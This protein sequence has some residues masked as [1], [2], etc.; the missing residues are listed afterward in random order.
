MAKKKTKKEKNKNKFEYNNEIIGVIIILLGIIGL[1]G[2]GIVGNIVKSF[3]IFL[4]GTIYVAL[5]I[6]LLVIG[7]FLILKKD[8]PNLL[9]SRLIG[10]YI[11]IISFLVILH[12]KYIEVNGT[13]S[14]KIITETF[15]NLLLSFSNN[16]ALSN[17]GGGIIGAIFSYLFVTAFGDGAQIVIYTMF[18]LGV[19]LTLNVSI[20]DVYNKIKPHISNLF[21]RDK[22]DEEEAEE[23]PN[24]KV[25]IDDN[26]NNSLEPA[27]VVEP[28]K[29]EKI[30]EDVPIV[31]PQPKIVSNESEEIPDEVIINSSAN[32]QLPSINLLNTVKNVSNKENEVKAKENIVELEKVLK[33]FDISGKVVQVNI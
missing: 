11:I 7:V 1:L 24:I 27:V 19:I 12:V 3:A 32:Y 10:I 2:T 26:K 30:D 21:N 31:R 5:L 17:S 23:E 33:D 22:E 9:S 20:L 8:V 6:L 28:V 25:N 15:N 4:V 29:V 18:V 16:S 13:E 14:I